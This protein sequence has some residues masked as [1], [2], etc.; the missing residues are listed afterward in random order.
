MKYLL[1]VFSTL[2]Q[3]LGVQGLQVTELYN[4]EP[5]EVDHLDPLGL[6]FCYLC[7]EDEGTTD[8]V[9]NEY[10]VQDPDA[11]D[12]WFAHQLNDDGCASQAI[13]NILLNCNDVRLGEELSRFREDTEKMNSIVSVLIEANKLLRTELMNA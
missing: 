2:L 4:L 6:I 13:L 8:E 7:P 11:E 12:L 10:D 9:A 5:Y 1:G 3:K